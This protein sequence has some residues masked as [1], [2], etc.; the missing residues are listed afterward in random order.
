MSYS[1]DDPNLCA[2]EFIEYLEKV[3]SHLISSETS[4]KINAQVL[5]LQEERHRRELMQAVNLELVTSALCRPSKAS[6]IS[7][8]VCSNLR[9]SRGTRSRSSSR[10]PPQTDSDCVTYRTN[11][12]RINQEPQWV[13]PTASVSAEKTT[14]PSRTPSRT[15]SMSSPMSPTPNSR[16][17]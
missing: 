3:G 15:S 16:N 8:P 7:S 1:K 12:N 14:S 4:S 11:N 17:V 6:R 9:R 10:R 13:R 2:K 5:K